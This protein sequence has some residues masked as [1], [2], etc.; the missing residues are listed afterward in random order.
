MVMLSVAKN[1]LLIRP[2]ICGILVCTAVVVSIRRMH[3][4]II[5]DRQLSYVTE[6][7]LKQNNKMPN[8]IIQ[9]SYLLH[10]RYFLVIDLTSSTK[11]GHKFLCKIRMKMA[12]LIVKSS[13]FILEKY[14]S[15]FTI[16]VCHLCHF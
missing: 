10:I 3:C 6:I 8:E 11:R 15:W 1:K 12:T 7:V 5:C 4:F 14:Y 16:M 13:L 2:F 9:H